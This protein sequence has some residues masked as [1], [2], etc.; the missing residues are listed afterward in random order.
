LGL[1]RSIVA[2]AALATVLLG[3]A[4]SYVY[5]RWDLDTR[6]GYWI[7]HAHRVI[8]S[9]LLVFPQLQD[10]VVTER[11][12]VERL[13]PA[14]LAAYRRAVDAIRRS[15]RL[16]Q[17]LTTDN[18]MQAGRA[19]AVAQALERWVAWSAHVAD[20]ARAGDGASAK[21]LLD[22]GSGR[23]PLLAARRAIQALAD[24][25]RRILGARTAHAQTFERASFVIGVV[26]A[27]LA[28][29]GLVGLIVALSRAN[30]RLM[31]A[32]QEAQRSQQALQTSQALT[33]ALFDNSPD[34]LMV[35]QIEGPDRYVVGDINPAL[36]EAFGVTPEAVRGRAID[37]LFPEP[38]TQ[39]LI[40]HYALV[41]A[42]TAPVWSRNE[43]PLPGRGQR[44]WDAILAPVRNASGEADRIVGVIRDL[45]D[46]VKTEERLAQSQ[47][48]EAVGQLTGGVAHDF[49]NLLQ[50]IRGNLELLTAEVE[51]RPAARRRLANA[52]QGADRAAQ[53]TTQLLA[54]ARRQPLA[55]RVIDPARQVRATAELLRRTLGEGVEVGAKIAADAWPTLVDPAQ[56][57]S[58]ILNLAL[59]ARDAMPG[60]GRVAIEAD[61]ATL[62]EAA[63]AELEIAP[64]DYVRIAVCDTGE[65]IP[66]GVL[67]RVFEPFFTTKG[68]G[69]GT[70]LG[71]SMVYGFA[72]QSQG[73]VRIVSRP[74]EG[75][76]VC[77]YLP[78]STT[79]AT[80]AT[81]APGS[82][83]AGAAGGSQTILVV[84]DDPD[85][86]GAA[87]AMLE[88]LGYRC[89]EAPDAEAA[90][91]TFGDGT[92]VDL[93]FSDVVMPGPLNARD[94]AQALR[95]R[96]PALAVLFT[97]GYARDVIVHDGRLDAGVTLLPK[98]YS[99]DA[100]AAKLTQMLR[101][102]PTGAPAGG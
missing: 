25:E 12:Y 47:R 53:L 27:V 60:G 85:V 23:P 42:A 37:E 87:V 96:V 77:L 4:G 15:E 31:R 16:L 9:S 19:A 50:V 55:P 6:T 90:L 52:I 5:T 7:D 78:R 61:N 56:L 58:A 94:F 39:R 81:E 84:E 68:D 71:L 62:D 83:V 86:R 18:P 98:P 26:L 101:Q 14:D 1:K 91:E 10:A 82:A 32:A 72:R 36:A 67:D 74:G 48:L 33:R 57:E 97:S 21:A 43:V 66:A 92:G 44:V 54:F 59:N 70:G 63:A 64:G 40:A 75:T 24:G 35:L 69:K 49:N 46:R 89:R 102:A 30:I 38:M 65:G 79:E 95:R 17:S 29:G 99:R 22:S 93:V 8:E 20:L 28:L 13:R 73:T 51:D 34:Y 2:A 100:L 80:E 11:G 45:T 88:S 41:R 76:Q 3:L